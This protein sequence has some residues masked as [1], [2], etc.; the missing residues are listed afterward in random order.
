MTAR[1][2]GSSRLARRAQNRRSPIVAFRPHSPSNSEV[3]RNPESTKKVSTPRNPAGRNGTPL[4]NA[5]TPST[6]KARTPSRAGMEPRLGGSAG[7][8][9]PAVPT[10]AAANRRADLAWIATSSTASP[11]LRLTPRPAA[12]GRLPPSALSLA[13]APFPLAASSRGGSRHRLSGRNGRRRRHGPAGG[14]EPCEEPLGR[15]RRFLDHEVADGRHHPR[16]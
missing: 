10:P 16:G 2:A 8:S 7:A 5:M 4:W 11:G 6:A 9:G 15:Q 12:A 1:R 3:M 14:V 13:D